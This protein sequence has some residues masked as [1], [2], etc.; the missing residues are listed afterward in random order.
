MNNPAHR[1]NPQQNLQVVLERTV[2]ARRERVFR[3][4]TDPILMEKWF[5]PVSMKPVGI[6]AQAVVGGSYRIG[7][8]DQDGTIHYVRGKY[9]E[10]LPPERLVFTWAWETEPPSVDSLVTVEFFEQGDSTRILLKHEQLT[11]LQ[12]QESHRRGWE[13]CLEHLEL[14]IQSGEI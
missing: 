12:S 9:I 10:I 14:G 1:A 13:G 7:M 4:W 8:R 6:E 2:R 3:A 5:S 11:T